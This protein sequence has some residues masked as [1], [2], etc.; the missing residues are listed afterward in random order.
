MKTGAVQPTKYSLCTHT[1]ERAGGRQITPTASSAWFHRKRSTEAP[2]RRS[3]TVI[4]VLSSAGSLSAGSTTAG[5]ILS[6]ITRFLMPIDA[7]PASAPSGHAPTVSIWGFSAGTLVDRL[8]GNPGGGFLKWSP[9]SVFVWGSDD[10]TVGLWDPSSGAAQRMLQD[11]PSA[12]VQF[13]WQAAPRAQCPIARGG[14][15]RPS[16]RS[17]M[18]TTA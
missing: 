15:R 7:L 12:V 13:A 17:R 18:P 8:T 6:V 11:H 4:G 1:A 3:I 5:I 14:I 9:G 2:A 10:S 16:T